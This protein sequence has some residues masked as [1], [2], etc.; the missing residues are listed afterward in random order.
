MSKQT[1]LYLT[2]EDRRKLQELA[3]M[4]EKKSMSDVVRSL[5]AIAYAT[6][7]KKQEQPQ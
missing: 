1:N 6:L 2:D 7:A 5:I 3:A 4:T